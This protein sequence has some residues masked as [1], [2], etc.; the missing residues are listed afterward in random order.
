MLP[1]YIGNV[2]AYPFMSLRRRMMLTYKVPANAHI[3]MAKGR[4]YDLVKTVKRVDSI[5]EKEGIFTLWSGVAVYM[6]RHLL[7]DGFEFI[8]DSFI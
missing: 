1:R 7:Q 2:S 8:F 4:E 6:A 3:G 5:A